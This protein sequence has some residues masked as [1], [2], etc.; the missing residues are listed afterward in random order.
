MKPRLVLIIILIIY[1]SGFLLHTLILQKTV[2]GDGIYYF[3][4]LRSIVI[5]QDLNFTNEYQQFGVQSFTTP[6]GIPANK[7]G[8]GPAILASPFYII[9][10][11]IVRRTGYELPYQLAF[12]LSGVLYG[13]V[14]LTLIYLLISQKFGNA[15]GIFTTIVIAFTTNLLFYGSLDTGNSHVYTF[16]LATLLVYIISSTKPNFWLA[17]T[18]LGLLGLT[19]MQDVLYFIMLLPLL[20]QKSVLPMGGPIILTMIIQM[21]VWRCLYGSLVINPYGLE[22]EGFNFTQPHILEI[23]FSPKF[24]L[25]TWSPSLIFA[26][27][28][29]LIK[30]KKNILINLV[31]LILV[32]I[33]VVL[34][35]SWSTWWQGASYGGRMFVSLLPIWALGL[36]NFWRYMSRY[37]ITR[38]YLHLI[39]VIPLSLINLIGIIY[40]LIINK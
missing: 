40:F 16:F 18:T 39:L 5:D 36:G 14:G 3:S 15:A 6:L 19:R 17:G 30:L 37:E 35:S 7:Y 1:L 8:I 24:G 10:H 4:W 38:K 9:T 32:G 23:L 12:G 31:P 26:L 27:T 11:N 29:L 20:T 2:Y 21:S 25:I 28:G 33:Q 13:I 34:V 22:G